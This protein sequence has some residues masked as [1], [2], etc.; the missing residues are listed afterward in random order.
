MINSTDQR[1]LDL[2]NAMDFS[3]EESKDESR[4][5][6]IIRALEAFQSVVSSEEPL[7]PELQNKVLYKIIQINTKLDAEERSIASRV[8]GIFQER[9]PGSHVLADVAKKCGWDVTSFIQTKDGKK[10]FKAAA[11]LIQEGMD[12]EEIRDIFRA[13]KSISKGEREDVCL[14]VASLVTEDSSKEEV[15]AIINSLQHLDPLLRR[16]SCAAIRPLIREGGTGVSDLL[17]G[18]LHFRLSYMSR[19]CRATAHFLKGE[20]SVQEISG[21]F[22]CVARMQDSQ[23]EAV[24]RASTFLIDEDM[25]GEEVIDCLTNIQE[26]D[27]RQRYKICELTSLFVFEDNSCDDKID[28]LLFIQ[29]IEKGQRESI[30]MA[31][32]FFIKEEISAPMI[33]SILSSI[34]KMPESDRYNH[35]AVVL[36]IK[37]NL[38]DQISDLMQDRD[39]FPRVRD[40]ADQIGVC[41]ELLDL[42]EGDPLIEMILRVL[43]EMGPEDGRETNM[44]VLHEALLEK[45]KEVVSPEATHVEIEGII[46][47]LKFKNLLD[48]AKVREVPVAFSELREVDPYIFTTLFNAFIERIESCS[49]EERARIDQEIEVYIDEDIQSAFTEKIGVDEG[50]N[51]LIECSTGSSRRIPYWLNY[52]PG[53]GEEIA[54]RGVVEMN[55]IAELLR[56]TTNEVQEGEGISP[57]ERMLIG[58]A[59]TVATCRQGQDEGI[60]LAYLGISKERGILSQGEE[61]SKGGEGSLEN[62]TKVRELLQPMLQ[63]Q[64]DKIELF[65]SLKNELMKKLVKGEEGR[66]ELVHQTLYLKNLLNEELGIDHKEKR[67]LYGSYVDPDLRAMSKEEILKE[68]YQ[69]YAD[70]FVS[71]AQRALN[72]GR[73]RLELYN[74]AVG[75]MGDIMPE[76]AVEFNEENSE[77]T[78]TRKGA[79][80]VLA[81]LGF[82]KCSP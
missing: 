19:I 66:G 51:F 68:F 7:A 14:A 18:I 13:V 29:A 49:L 40:I 67:D 31:G 21:I 3:I 34:G 17:K 81:S 77:F 41:E 11:C 6:I 76:D 25:T 39:N 8:E 2:I 43:A 4:Y 60:H 62:Q 72:E 22:L 70:D 78:F 37:N 44:Y 61:E 27:E 56:H 63:T 55:E 54:P 20:M 64:V 82:F 80:R 30:C 35:R 32:L 15:I 65:L 79:L 1:A 73:N 23:R 28:L 57:Q 53:R 71:S 24:C 74:A 47:D 9:H 45:K 38:H 69:Y 52:T 36:A 5:S 12:G 59:H 48:A 26:I 16:E 10:V 42:Q 33:K 75:L 50:I 58:L 46:A